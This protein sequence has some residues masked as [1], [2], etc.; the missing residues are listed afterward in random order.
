M[1]QSSAV[2]AP[3]KDG[4]FVLEPVCATWPYF[5]K[6]G[7]VYGEASR[8]RTP[9]TE[10]FTTNYTLAQRHQHGKRRTA[11]LTTGDIRLR[12]LSK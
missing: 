6:G 3:G 1:E 8:S 9:A 5:R 2:R 11:R 7:L 10:G 4:T 12:P